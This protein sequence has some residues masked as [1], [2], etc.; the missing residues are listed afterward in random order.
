MVC[1]GHLLPLLLILGALCLFRHNHEPQVAIKAARWH[2]HTDATSSGTEK[3]PMSD[4]RGS[5]TPA[6]NAGTHQYPYAASLI[7]AII[8]VAIIYLIIT[9]GDLALGTTGAG[10]RENEGEGD[11]AKTDDESNE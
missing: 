11:V 1:S 3:V 9:Y 8:C 7:T 10:W 5:F 4:I 6:R 2:K